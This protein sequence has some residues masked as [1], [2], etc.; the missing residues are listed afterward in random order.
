[1]TRNVYRDGP[2][3]PDEL[4][5]APARSPQGRFG[6]LIGRGD[7]KVTFIDETRIDEFLARLLASGSDEPLG[8]PSISMVRQAQLG[9][10][11]FTAAQRDAPAMNN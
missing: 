9:L 2:A 4:W 1:M 10:P 8:G 5:C 6:V 11:R 7:M 3:K